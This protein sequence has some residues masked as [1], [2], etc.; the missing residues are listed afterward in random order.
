MGRDL[1][2]VR[3]SKSFEN[4]SEEDF[5]SMVKS[6]RKGVK[7]EYLVFVIKNENET[8]KTTFEFVKNN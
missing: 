6:I 5:A 7:K 1:L 4:I 3:L 2:I 8:N